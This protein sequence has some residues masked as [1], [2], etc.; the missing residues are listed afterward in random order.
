MFLFMPVLPKWGVFSCIPQY[1]IAWDI[2]VSLAP[3]MLKFRGMLWSSW[4]GT[5]LFA[6]STAS[7]MLSVWPGVPVFP[8]THWKVVIADLCF[9]RK[10]AFLNMSAFHILIQPWSSQS[11]KCLISPSITYME[12]VLISSGQK[13][14]TSA[15][16]MIN[17]TTFPLWLDCSD[18]RTL[19]T[20]FLW[21]WGPNQ[22]PLPHWA[23]SLPL[24]VHVLLVCTIMFSCL[25]FWWSYLSLC[26]GSLKM[27]CGS[28]KD[29]NAFG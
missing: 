23:S 10:V 29:P 22:I 24:W 3:W 14:C 28:A 4:S 19:N 26:A 18:P 13:W 27:L 21:S 5:C 20:L 25:L 15:I 16:A 7:L 6:P 1:A 17:A 11:H 2:E 12:S 8:A 9:R